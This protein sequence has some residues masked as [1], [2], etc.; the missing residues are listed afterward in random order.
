MAI[1]KFQQAID[2]NYFKEFSKIVRRKYGNV[3]SECGLKHGA[4]VTRKPSGEYIEADDF[5]ANFLKKS[6]VRVFKIFLH[7]VPVNF[8]ENALILEN[9]TVLCPF[10][11]R[12]HQLRELEKEKKNLNGEFGSLK[13]SHVLE[14]KNYIHAITGRRPTTRDCVQILLY[15]DK[16]FQNQTHL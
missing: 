16:I 10:H 6:G 4:T 15:F 9:Y 1:N 12:L 2:R 7:C 3:C 14:L 11:A 5:E 13:T 8:S